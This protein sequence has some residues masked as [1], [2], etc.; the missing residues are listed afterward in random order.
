MRP[1]GRPCSAPRRPGFAALLQAPAPKGRG[2]LNPVATRRRRNAGPGLRDCPGRTVI[3]ALRRGVVRGLEPSAI[4]EVA[5]LVAMSAARFFGLPVAPAAGPVAAAAAVQRQPWP[6]RFASG[7]WSPR[8]GRWRQPVGGETAACESFL[9][10]VSRWPG[11][12]RRRLP[13]MVGP[14]PVQRKRR[15]P[16]HRARGLPA[17]AGSGR[18]RCRPGVEL[19]PDPAP[20]G[21]AREM[22]EDQARTGSACPDGRPVAL[23]LRWTRARCQ[24]LVRPR[25]SCRLLIGPG[26]GTGSRIGLGALALE[27]PALAWAAREPMP[28][29]GTKVF[30]PL[31]RRCRAWLPHRSKP[32]RPHWAIR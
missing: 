25:Q 6:Q 9:H 28:S 7:Q 15:S 3:R 30:R 32:C 26:S 27:W 29:Q 14:E 1:S 23:R 18:R 8:R 5:L 17:R 19:S 24:R 4:S 31:P 16:A 13:W 2:L 11:R 10:V 12:A 20:V 21:A 22:C